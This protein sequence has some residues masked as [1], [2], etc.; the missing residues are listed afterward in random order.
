MGIFVP[1][2]HKTNLVQVHSQHI[3]FHFPERK[4][5]TAYSFK[6]KSIF[7]VFLILKTEI[8]NEN[9]IANKNTTQL[10]STSLYCFIH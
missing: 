9:I 1:L 5:S 4:N 2:Q 6:D 7:L 8:K 3:F 10:Y